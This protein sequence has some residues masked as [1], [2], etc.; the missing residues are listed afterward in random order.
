MATRILPAILAAVS[1]AACAA[2]SQ[3]F[4]DQARSSCTAGD[5]T[6]CGSVAGL[7]AQVNYEHQVQSQEAAA[8]VAAVL[9]ALAVGAAAGYAATRPV[10]YEPVVVC[11]GWRCY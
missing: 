10:Y 4:L 5:Q 7:Q 2:P 9:G 3:P 8:G 6:A 11:R 1:L